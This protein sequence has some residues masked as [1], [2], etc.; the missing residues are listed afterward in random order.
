[1]ARGLSTGFELSVRALALPAML[2][3]RWTTALGSAR[4]GMPEAKRSLALALKVVADEAFFA[5]EAL[6]GALALGAA[7]SRARS[8]PRKRSTSG[9]AGPRGP[10]T[11]T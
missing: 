1:V 7:A 2:G 9:A 11:T 6:S 8:A 10:R 4:R 3:L 5:T